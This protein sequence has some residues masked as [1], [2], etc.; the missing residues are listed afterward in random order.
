MGRHNA[1]GPAS[2]RVKNYA[3]GQ[4][5]AHDS[6]AAPNA[7]VL[8]QMFS[9]LLSTTLVLLLT[10]RGLRLGWNTWSQHAR[11]RA[12]TLAAVAATVAS[13]VDGRL[14]LALN[15]WVDYGAARWTLRVRAPRSGRGHS[16]E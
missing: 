9:A 14:R 15:T 6:G 12:R 7:F 16:D 3:H 11:E 10:A 4:D 8:L 2:L 1:K 13:L 5:A